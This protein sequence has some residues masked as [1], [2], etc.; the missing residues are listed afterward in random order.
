MGKYKTMRIAIC[1][2]DN[3]QVELS[4]SYLNEWSQLGKHQTEI[5]T[6]SSAEAFLFSLEDDGPFDVLLLDIQM[7]E[8]TGIEL[9]KK[10]RRQ[11]SDVIIIFITAIKEF[12]FE[13]YDVDAL[14]YILKPISREKLF[15]V[16]DKSCA[17]LNKSEPI[18]I[19]DNQ[20]IKQSDIIYIESQAHYID[21][22]LQD[23][24]IKVKKS[25][26]EIFDL[27]DKSHFIFSHRSY[28]VNIS[29]IE[30]ILKEEVLLEHEYLVPISRAKYKEI[31]SAFISFYTGGKL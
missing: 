2:D 1:E 8:M 10:L 26:K 23:K 4:K 24:V 9:A 25:L 31:N 7:S 6:Y 14:Q 16:L 28:I 19:I 5:C 27:L 13:G 11:R 29:K 3:T 20:K 18:I 12:V 15:S 22:Y 30:R 17:K 21:I